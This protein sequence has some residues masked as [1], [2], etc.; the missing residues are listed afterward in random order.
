[1]VLWG[2]QGLWQLQRHWLLP[3]L[4]EHLLQVLVVGQAGTAVQ[5]QH[6]LQFLQGP[7]GY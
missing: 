2:L 6:L 1:M 3:L 5:Q 7:G 4:A